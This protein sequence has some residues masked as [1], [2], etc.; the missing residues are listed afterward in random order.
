[1]FSI[2]LRC[3]LSDICL[4]IFIA[5]KFGMAKSFVADGLDEKAVLRTM[6]SHWKYKPVPSVQKNPTHTD[7]SVSA[8]TYSSINPNHGLSSQKSP[9]KTV[10]PSVSI[11]SQ[12]IR[13]EDL[14]TSLVKLP[15]SGEFP[16]GNIQSGTIHSAPASMQMRFRV[17]IQN[18]RNQ[19][20]RRR[21]DTDADTDAK[22]RK[23][24]I[25]R[26]SSQPFTESPSISTNSP[27]KS[28]SIHYA[29]STP[30]L[31]NEI[32]N[33]FNSVST[34]TT[35][36]AS[37]LTLNASPSSSTKHC[38][39]MVRDQMTKETDSSSLDLSLTDLARQC[40][41]ELEML[42]G[43]E[44]ELENNIASKK[45][46]SYLKQQSEISPSPPHPPPPPPPPPL[47]IVTLPSSSPTMESLSQMSL[48]VLPKPSPLIG[49]GLSFDYNGH[50][51]V[52]IRGGSGHSNH[53][54]RDTIGDRNSS[55]SERN[56]TPYVFSP[57][58]DDSGRTPS[59]SES[60]PFA[61]LNDGDNFSKL[62]SNFFFFSAK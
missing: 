5:Q 51:K 14:I 45:R 61:T 11:S 44:L 6:T 19:R 33:A 53:N 35:E 30:N 37:G 42:L 1:M 40:T 43:S 3:F 20:M 21:S 57:A 29:S 24:K 12:D 27:L 49:F 2:V 15:T 50:D 32:A 16:K 62:I 41:V 22:L 58:F 55:L 34:T 48:Y 13:K 59:F 9:I 52:S 38:N 8:T 54:S 25:A 26:R 47:S 46:V 18:T 36:K 56:R 28:P 39:G 10:T 17:D 23:L 60:T 4:I 7:P 31:S